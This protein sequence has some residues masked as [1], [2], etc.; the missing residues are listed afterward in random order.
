MNCSMD[1]L[2]IKAEKMDRKSKKKGGK[3][4]KDCPKCN[5]VN[6]ARSSNCKECDYEFYIRK[7]KKQE[8]L[9]ANWKELKTGD[10]IKCIA[11]HGT[12][13]L[14]N[15]KPLNPDGS[16]QRIYMSHKGKF[17]VLKIVDQG[18][19]SCG[20]LGHQVSSR[21]VVASVREYIYMGEKYKNNDLSLYYEPHKIKVL[22][23]D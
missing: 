20:I 22:K 6:H 14:S 13:F 9:A 4:E 18:K 8:L 19:R 10:I 7:N 11:G 1:N 5:C 2:T 15:D 3:P 12:Y 17:R 16:K 21:G 23:N